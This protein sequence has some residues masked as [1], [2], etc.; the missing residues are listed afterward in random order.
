VTDS[1]QGHIPV[2]V[3]EVLEALSPKDTDT[4]IDGTFGAGG[5]S[6]AL[7][8]HVTKGRLVGIERDPWVLGRGRTRLEREVP[9]AAARVDLVHGSFADLEGTLRDLGLD[10]YDVGL[11]D[12]GINSLQVDEGGRGFHRDDE[13]LDLRFD[14]TDEMTTDAATALTH[15]SERA[16]ADALHEL[17]GERLSRPIARAIVRRREQGRPVTTAQDLAALVAGIYR[18]H[19]IRRQRIHPV[20]RTA[21][22]LRM[23]INDELGHLERGLT[24]FLRS[25][26]PAARLAVLTFHSGEARVVKRVFRAAVKGEHEDLPEAMRFDWIHRGALKPSREEIQANARA[27]SSQLRALRRVA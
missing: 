26:R 20:T 1:A 15:W 13:K 7:L 27:R 19:G 8:R 22:G 21:Q 6:L 14:P 3:G 16:L 4:V 11:L 5:H 10:G 25:M 23:A 24:A 9:G 2:M 17:G 12:L 18:R